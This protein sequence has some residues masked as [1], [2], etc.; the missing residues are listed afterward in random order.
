MKKFVDSLTIDNPGLIYGKIR[1]ATAN[2][3]AAIPT[4][5]D[6]DPATGIET[7][8]QTDQEKADLLVK[9]YAQPPK[10]PDLSSGEKQHAK[11]ANFVS[12][13]QLEKKLERQLG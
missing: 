13:C 11:V 3:L 4:L 2:R 12:D 10:P 5:I 8:A 1:N 7:T 9:H 6:K